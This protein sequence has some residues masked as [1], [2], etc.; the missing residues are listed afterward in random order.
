MGILIA[1]SPFIFVGGFYA[2][3]GV[4]H[5]AYI[6]LS[7][8]ILRTSHLSWKHCLIFAFAMT[9]LSLIVR[10]TLVG[11]REPLASGLFISPALNMTMGGWFFGRRVLTRQGQPFGWIGGMQ[12]AVISFAFLDLTSIVS[13]GLLHHPG[14]LQP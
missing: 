7:A 4:L 11:A 1:F 3:T 6:K 14:P 5:A 8:R 13:N 10:M 2:L 9:L 12:L